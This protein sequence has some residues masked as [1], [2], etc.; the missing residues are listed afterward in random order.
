MNSYHPLLRD[1]QEWYLANASVTPTIEKLF[2]LRG[3]YRS[4]TGNQ[5]YELHHQTYVYGYGPLY[6]QLARSKELEQQKVLGFYPYIRRPSSS[7]HRSHNQDSLGA[8]AGAKQPEIIPKLPDQGLMAATAATAHC[9]LL[10]CQ[11]VRLILQPDVKIFEVLGSKFVRPM[12]R[13]DVDEKLSRS[14]ATTPFEPN[15]SW[16]LEPNESP[17]EDPIRQN[18]ENVYVKSCY[19]ILQMACSLPHTDS[20]VEAL[21]QRLINEDKGRQDVLLNLAFQF[22][23]SC[24][25]RDDLRKAYEKC[26]D[27]SQESRALIC[28]F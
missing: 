5:A 14:L 16:L 9:G 17:T 1:E 25:V 27:I 20:E 3:P 23:D 11:T 28:T 24:A 21:V 12:E 4:D 19:K 2:F 26:N 15:D 22:E 10:A 13:G 6:A 8:R 7:I 18:V